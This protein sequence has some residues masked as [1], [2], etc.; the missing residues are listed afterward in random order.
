MTIS[1]VGPSSS[2]DKPEEEIDSSLL[3]LVS[4]TS[5]SLGLVCSSVCLLM[6]LSDFIRF[7]SNN[8]EL[9]ND[10]D[11]SGDAPIF[12]FYSRAIDVNVFLG[13]ETFF[14]ESGM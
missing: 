7:K 6:P 12:L 8:S 14:P 11:V 2:S 9:L 10:I 1:S 3:L 4:S 13:T 5:I